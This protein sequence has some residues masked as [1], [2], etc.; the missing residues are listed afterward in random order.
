MKYSDWGRER[1]AGG[2]GVSTG[3]SQPLYTYLGTETF[4]RCC[5]AGGREGGKGTVRQQEAQKGSRCRRLV[6]LWHPKFHCFIGGTFSLAHVALPRRS[7]L[8]GPSM[9][10]L[11]MRPV[12]QPLK[13]IRDSG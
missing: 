5:K 8:S 3:V 2:V 13:K 9:R 11:G 10:H 6:L 12:R 4:E 1:T 7:M